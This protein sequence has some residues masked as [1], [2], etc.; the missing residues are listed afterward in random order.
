MPIFAC[1]RFGRQRT[2][3]SAAPFWLA[4]TDMIALM[5][6]QGLDEPWSSH[7]FIDEITHLQRIR[8]LHSSCAPGEVQFH[9]RSIFC[10]AALSDYLG[11]PRSLLLS[12]ELERVVAQQFYQ[13]EAFFIRGLGFIEPTA[14]RRISFEDAIRFERVHEQ[15]YRDFG[16]QLVFVEPGAPLD[17]ANQIKAFFQMRLK[18]ARLKYPAPTVDLS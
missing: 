8:L 17:R 16:F 7:S 18:Q 2:P 13:P 10:T 15:V 14:A 9:D 3:L 1:R 4:A 11:R 5:H 6:A 12:Q